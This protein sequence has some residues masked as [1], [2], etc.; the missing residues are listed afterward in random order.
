[1]PFYLIAYQPASNGCSQVAAWSVAGR[2][3]AAFLTLLA[4][5]LFLPSVAFAQTEIH[6]CT[7]ADGGTVF[8]QLPCTDELPPKPEEPAPKAESRAVERDSVE[9]KA[10]MVEPSD[11][12]RDDPRSDEE[13]AAC[14]KRYRD[15]IDVIDAE[16]GRDYT[17]EKADDF[18]QRLLALTAELRRC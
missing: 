5:S 6:R 18:K 2:Y 7:D 15:A 11:D 13:R 12:Q 17:A 10:F 3:R 14:K 4:G 9:P 16:I 8:S 1:M